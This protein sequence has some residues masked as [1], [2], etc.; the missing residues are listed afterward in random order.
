MFGEE[1]KMNVIRQ[2]DIQFSYLATLDPLA[3]ALKV[4]FLLYYTNTK[5]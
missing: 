2:F 5:L 3:Q 1:N 4:L